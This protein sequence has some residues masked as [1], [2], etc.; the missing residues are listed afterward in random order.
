LESKNKVQVYEKNE[1]LRLYID[2]EFDDVSENFE[3]KVKEPVM[4]LF[5]WSVLL[6]RN[7][8]AKIFWQIGEVRL[9]HQLVCVNLDLEYHFLRII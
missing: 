4:N 7:E 6:N 3:T 2:N 1:K 9:D 8:M 5:V